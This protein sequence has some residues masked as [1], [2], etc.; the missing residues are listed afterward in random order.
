M[1]LVDTHVWEMACGDKCQLC[2]RGSLECLHRE[3]LQTKCRQFSVLLIDVREWRNTI[4]WFCNAFNMDWT[5]EHHCC[6]Q[7]T[8]LVVWTQRQWLLLQRHLKIPQ[9]FHA[10][11]KKTTTC[12]WK[13]YKL[14]TDQVLKKVLSNN[15]FFLVKVSG[16]AC[17]GN[18]CFVLEN[19]RAR[20][21]CETQILRYYTTPV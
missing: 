15:N 9:T 10:W 8:S 11:I 17:K 12:K 6:L 7:M 2:N 13:G 1:H 21:I 16:R 20:S 18:F 5:S 14:W 3:Q 19:E 4:N